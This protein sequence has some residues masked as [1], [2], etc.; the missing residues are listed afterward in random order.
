MKKLIVLLLC[1]LAFE[2]ALADA[3]E[4]VFAYNVFEPWKRLDAQGRPAGPYTEIVR[5]LARR[6]GL[7]LRY[8]HC[9]LSRCL[10]T[11]QQGRADLMIGVRPTVE[12]ARYLDFLEPPFAN[13]DHLAF[14]QRRDDA[15][16]IAR[17][18]DLLPLTVGV[19]EGVSYL[20]RFDR[21]ARIRRE[22]SPGMESGFRKLAA[23]RVDALIVNARQGA[24]LASRPEF[25]GR[26]RRAALTLDDSHP[27]RLALARRSPLHA[28]RARIEQALRAMVADGTAARILAVSGR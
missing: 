9:P 1:C 13:G 3:R 28:Q 24:L 21:D 10:A 23:G 11:M 5:E 25:A 12:R 17:Y 27:N 26:V 16:V 6:L 15:R 4:L 20:P 19:A 22:A 8:L 14:Y 7:P 2:P 18:E